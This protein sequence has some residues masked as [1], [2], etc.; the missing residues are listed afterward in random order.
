MSIFSGEELSSADSE[1]AFRLRRWR[2]DIVGD[3]VGG[4]GD[5]DGKMPESV[6]R[7]LE[8]LEK[9]EMGF[10]CKRVSEGATAHNVS[11]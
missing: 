3:K 2:V 8:K 5:R 6:E 9:R 11:M 4:G 10:G 1:M 7:S